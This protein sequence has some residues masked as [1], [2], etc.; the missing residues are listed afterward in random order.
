MVKCVL[1]GFSFTEVELQWA[2]TEQ[3]IMVL[4]S[5]QWNWTHLLVCESSKEVLNLDAGL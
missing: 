2:S 3:R 5:L 4:L 1:L